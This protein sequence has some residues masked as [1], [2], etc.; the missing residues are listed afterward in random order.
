MR[1]RFVWA[2]AAGLYVVC[3]TSLAGVSWWFDRALAQ[4]TGLTQS[5]YVASTEGPAV[6]RH[7][8][9]IELRSL[10]RAIDGELRSIRVTWEGLWYFPGDATIDL[11]AWADD[12]VLWTL[13]GEVVIEHDVARDHEPGRRR[14][15]VG[16]GFHDLSVTYDQRGGGYALHVQWAPVGQD[17]R[18]LP[19]ER[20]FRSDSLEQAQHTLVVR[21][22]ARGFWLGVP[23]VLVLAFIVKCAIRATARIV[24]PPESSRVET[25][26]PRAATILVSA[27]LAIAAVARYWG[28][29]FGLPHTRSR[30]DEEFLIAMAHRFM[31][32]HLDPDFFIYPPLYAYGLTVV[33]FVYYLWGYIGGVFGAPI[34]VAASWHSYWEPFFLLSRFQSAALGTAT[35]LVIYRMGLRL[36]DRET[37]VA[38]AF[39]LALAFLHSFLLALAFLHARD[40]HFGTVDVAQTLLILLSIHFLL[41]AHQRPGWHAY[42]GAGA[43]GGLAMATKYNAALLCVPFIADWALHILKSRGA[44]VRAAFDRR[45]VFFAVPLVLVFLAAAP[46]TIFGFERFMETV[47]FIRQGLRTGAGFADLGYG[48][49]HHVSWT[50]R[51]G[52][53]IP[54]LVA[55]LVGLMASARKDWKSTL[56]LC[57]FPVA[58]YVVMGSYRWVFARYMVPVVPFLCLFAAVGIVWVGRHVTSTRPGMPRALVTVGLTVAVLWPSASRLLQFDRL[59]TRTDSRVVA[60]R[61]VYDH[62]PAGSTILQNGGAYGQVQFD[63]T[64]SYDEWTETQVRAAFES[65]TGQRGQTDWIILYGSPLGRYVEPSVSALVRERYELIEVVKGSGSSSAG[66]E[67]DLQDAFFV[68]YAGFRDVVRPGPDIRIYRKRPGGAARGLTSR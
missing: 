7:V 19:A 63:R 39:L 5:I 40:S 32:G 52:L 31:Q 1:R 45:I 23:L 66:N 35:V 27:A 54:L 15:F 57:G 16:K 67:F 36:F 50:L 48:W 4:N 9:E 62:V 12:H 53:G 38:A 28:I 21:R 34:D 3:S 14:L 11:E 6:R 44:R 25:L 49:T 20:L 29:D 42:V 59:V 61:W 64:D 43:L 51:Y 60:A 22:F 13:D 26:S 24:V 10:E 17:L 68:P 30:P 8:A 58:Y 46:Y 47:Q 33:Y 2:A 56:L 41:R 37:A 55:S 65:D 18:P